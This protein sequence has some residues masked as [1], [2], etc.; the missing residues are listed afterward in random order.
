[1][2]TI[3]KKENKKFITDCT[4]IVLCKDAKV[5]NENVRNNNFRIEGK[6]SLEIFFDDNT[7]SCM[8][9][10]FCRF[11]DCNEV[12]SQYNSK[13]NFHRYFYNDTDDAIKAFHQ[14][15]YTLIKYINK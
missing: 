3:A 5:I 9:T 15:F 14:F 2:K 11:D 10:V 6:N 7:D 4:L 1:M 13:C 8:F 12:T